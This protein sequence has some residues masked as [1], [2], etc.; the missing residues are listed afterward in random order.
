MEKRREIG[1]KIL[2]TF[3]F[4]FVCLLSDLGSQLKNNILTK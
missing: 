2:L 4:I 1:R 3:L